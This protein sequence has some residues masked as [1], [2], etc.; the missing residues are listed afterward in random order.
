MELK[1]T[2]CFPY[3]LKYVPDLG[4]KAGEATGFIVRIR[5]DKKD[6]EGLLE[7]E[8]SHVRDC[9]YFLFL[10]YM[11]LLKF[12]WFLKWCE[13]RAYK[14]QLKYPPANGSVKARAQY[15]GFLATRYGL[16]PELTVE[17]AYRLLGQ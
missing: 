6:D 9:Y 16:N 8:L 12:K 7:H 1:F 15:A 13:V 2:Y 17:K 10:P 5:E 14:R 4:T 11:I 3:I